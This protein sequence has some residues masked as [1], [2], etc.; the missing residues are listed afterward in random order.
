MIELCRCCPKQKQQQQQR[1]APGRNSSCR[2]AMFSLGVIM[3]RVP[4]ERGESLKPVAAS[5]VNGFQWVLVHSV[6]LSPVVWGS[7]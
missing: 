4:R 3:P 7:L 5:A 2:G 1:A 6:V